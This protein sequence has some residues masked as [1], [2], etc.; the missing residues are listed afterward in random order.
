[1]EEKEAEL[2]VKTEQIATLDEAV[3]TLQTDISTLKEEKEVQKETIATQ[4]QLLN[5]AFYIVG[6]K[7]DLISA[8]VLSKGGLFRPARIS[9]EAEQST[10]MRIDIRKTSAIRLN[11]KKAK[12]L[13]LHPAGT[14]SLDQNE[15]GLLVLNITSPSAFWEQTKYLVIEIQ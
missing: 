15:S 5:T 7:N 12:V 6:N 14:Y 3:A 10:F 2:V 1:L 9:Y 4:D 11:S 8:R 13:S